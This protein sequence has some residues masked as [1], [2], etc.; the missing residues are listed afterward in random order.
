MKDILFVLMLFFSLT[1]LS[2]TSTKKMIAS[3]CH[4]GEGRCTGSAYC[5]ACKNCSRCAHCSN[6]GSCGVCSSSVPFETTTKKKTQTKSKSYRSVKLKSNNYYTIDQ[7]LIT[8]QNVNLRSGPSTDYEIFQ[9]L[10]K[11]SLVYF[12][13]KKGDWA[14]VKVKETN[15]V[16]YVNLKYLE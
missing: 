10:A 3:S 6:G 5:S 2:Q 9:F 11:G 12:K 7:L 14:L 8:T 13:E 15:R 4:D 16:G 1:C